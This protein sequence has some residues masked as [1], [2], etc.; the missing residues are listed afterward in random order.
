MSDADKGPADRDDAASGEPKWLL[1][2][3][4][5]RVQFRVRG[6]PWTAVHG[7]SFDIAPGESLGL[8]GESGSGKTSIARAL[9]RLVPATGSARFAG[10]DLLA[11]EGAELRAMRAQLQILFQDPLAALD[12]RMRIGESIGE[13]LREF[14][15][16]LADAD[17][18]SAVLAMMARVGLGE[19][20]YD[21]YPHEVSGGQAQRAGIARA[22]LPGP[23]LLV[24]DEPVASLDVSIKSQIS[25]LLR[26]LQRDLGLSLLYISH[27]LATVRYACDRL[28]VLYRGRIVESAARDALY[29]RPLH[30]YTQALL[31][32]VPVP[33]PSRQ[34]AQLPGVP[35][36]SAAH[37]GALPST[38][39]GGCAFRHRCPMAQARCASEAPALQRI[40]HSQVACHFA[41]A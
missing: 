29:A 21:R 26:E 18:R 37:L 40:G 13:P 36:A 5:L 8:V 41:Q 14:G 2:V 10:Q 20:L 33:D 34:S 3:R 22:L 27:D 39:G 4:D 11:L 15:A 32:A 17:R 25:N 23:R 19:A 35:P 30:P 9:L 31:A 16:R 7:A 1:S 6:R 12:P 38:A 28:I 24:C